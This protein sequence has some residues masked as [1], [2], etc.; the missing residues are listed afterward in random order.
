MMKKMFCWLIAVCLITA[1]F[2]VTAFAAET[3]S[4]GENAT[5]TLDGATL[6]ISGTGSTE[7][8]EIGDVPWYSK[9]T[10]VKT[11]VVEEGITRLGA[12]IFAYTTNATQAELPS[13]LKEI[14]Q[15]AF[16][17][18]YALA[19]A[20]LP[21]G[22][23][24]IGHGAFS[25]CKPLDGIVLPES[26]ERVESYAFHFTGL[27]TITIPRSITTL[28][29]HTFGSCKKLKEVHFHEGVDTIHDFCFSGCE[30]LKTIDLPDGLDEISWGCF[31]ISGLETITIPEGVEIIDSYAFDQCKNLEEIRIPN[32]VT[33]MEQYC[34]KDTDSL[35]TVDLPDG[36]K[37]TGWGMFQHGGLERIEL[38]EGLTK[39]T[40][41][42]FCDCDALTEVIIPDTVRYMEDFCFRDCG[43]LKTV[44]LPENLQY[45]GYGMFMDSALETLTIP[46]S[47]GRTE[48]YVFSGCDDLESIT[49][50]DRPFTF[51]DYAFA[52]CQGPVTFDLPEQL[53][54][55]S[56][57]M[58]TGS[59]IES[60][61]IPET[62][63]E[64]EDYAFCDCDFLEEVVFPDGITTM[65][66]YVFRNCDGLRSVHMPTSLKRIPWGCFWLSSIPELTIH[67]GVTEI[68]N[69]AFWDAYNLQKL[70]VPASVVR[71][72]TS[73]VFDGADQLVI[74]CW[75]DSFIHKYAE[76]NG[77]PYVLMD[78][79]TE[80]TEPTEPAEPSDPVNPF[81]DVTEEDFF[82]EPVLWAVEQGITT[83]TTEITFSPH[84]V[85][86]RAH[87]VTFLWRAMGCPEPESRVNPFADVK[88]TDFYYDAVLW[89]VERGITNGMTADTFGPY[90]VCNRAQ[91]VTFLH[92]ALGKPQGGGENPFDDVKTGDFFYD[93]VLWAVSENV[94]SGVDADSFGPGLDCVRAHVVTF[95]YRALAE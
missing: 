86:R 15:E 56:W 93:A 83:G 62:V 51:G 91:V 84:D 28:E 72:G 70:V 75:K 41:Y 39:V 12:K 22:L 18:C 44:A 11:I 17:A 60:I 31:S 82:Y 8:Y 71:V 54:Q 26:L 58:F 16:S 90:E 52:Y 66:D 9:R 24:V 45:L 40:E 27:T 74:W 92:R 36:L 95:L 59:T 76:E 64:V 87:V 69:Q 77:I 63:R 42:T 2:P 4:C 32:T 6:T 94:T 50:P 89:A 19:R 3:G 34:L 61:D 37:V 10:T 78:G 53:T 81:V 47:V 1:L 57:G 35:K 38:P 67:E 13:T 88:E 80:P 79:S 21:E 7:D 33:V 55:L 65:G 23:E 5:W 68:G 48:D 49:Y 25:S 46:D 30:S 85:C 29:E 14:G 20:D 73:K 43:S